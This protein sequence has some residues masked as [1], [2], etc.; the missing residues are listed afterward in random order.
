MATP[1]TASAVDNTNPQVCAPL[2]SGKIDVSGNHA[3]VDVTA[4]DGM[5]ISQYCVKAGSTQQGN[6]PVYQTVTPPV[7]S[8]T[9]TYPG[10]KDISHYSLSFVNVPVERIATAEVTFTDPSC[11]NGNK[12]ELVK[13]GEHVTWDVDGTVA[14]GHFVKV[15]AYASHG[16]KF[17]DGN[18]YVHTWTHKYGSTEDCTLYDAQASVEW[19][20]PSCENENTVG[21]V[22]TADENIKFW[23]EFGDWEPGGTVKVIAFTEP[24]HKFPG[25]GHGTFRVFTHTFGEAQYNCTEVT[26]LEPTF[27][28]PT[29]TT[30]P[31]VVLPT[32]PE[33]PAFRTAEPVVVG[34]VQYEVT[35]DLVAGG[36]VHVTASLVDPETT[37]WAPGVEKTT[38]DY[39]FVVPT[40]CTIVEPPIVEPPVVEPPVEEA[41][42]TEAETVTPTVVESGLAGQTSSTHGEG[43]ALMTAGLLVLA[44]AGAL[45]LRKGGE[46][47]S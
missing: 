17:A 37:H 38:W 20:E 22:K 26:P 23:K 36:T 5:L 18:M 21:Y 3:S 13:T 30:E 28:E 35:G 27:V 7:K 9:I 44:G 41:T 47:Q 42:E 24:G 10:G 45:R 15:T 34:P 25:D 16:Y 8:M 6:G 1:T 12:A 14:P 33:E 2:D 4:P 40:G 29:C 19:T 31:Q 32:A 39:T 46:R 11:E 43:L